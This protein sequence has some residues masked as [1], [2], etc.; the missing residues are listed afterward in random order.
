MQKL[1]VYVT[2]P[3]FFYVGSSV[4]S[5]MLYVLTLTLGSGNAKYFLLKWDVVLDKT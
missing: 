3:Q 5:L 2:E 1:L 4:C